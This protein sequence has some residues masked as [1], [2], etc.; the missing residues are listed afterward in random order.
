MADVAVIT[1]RYGT[2]IT[3]TGKAKI[4]AAILAGEKVNI[5]HVAVGDGGGAYYKPTSEQTDLINECWRGE[6]SSATIGKNSP[7]MIDIKFVV[8]ADQ[9]GYTI[10]EGMAIDKDGDVIAVWNTPDLQKVTVV[11]GVSFPL[12][13]LTHI[14]VEDAAAVTVTVNP[15][16]DT[17]SR[18]E[19]EQAIKTHNEGLT[20]HDDIR[21]ALGGITATGI[22]AIPVPLTAAVGQIIV[23]KAIDENGKPTEW[24]AMNRVIYL[25]QGT[26]PSDK[27]ILW[28]DTANESIIKFYNGTAWVP[29]HA[30]W[31]E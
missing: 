28:I 26:A 27:S 14:I 29:T 13:M 17:V 24:E 20:A 10:R 8:P 23:V 9:G 12:T 19:L 2:V 31:A 11:D 18:E 21:K 25:A 4:A 3:N 7:N 6:I 5:T 1:A 15:S 30:A 22:G 16:L